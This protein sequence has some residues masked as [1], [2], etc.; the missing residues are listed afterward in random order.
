MD[1]FGGIRRY[2]FSYVLL[3]GIFITIQTKEEVLLDMRASGDELGWLTWPL[4]QG[5]KT[6]VSKALLSGFS[7]SSHVSCWNLP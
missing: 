4:D 5:E 2:L 6:G 1:F 3:N 7:S